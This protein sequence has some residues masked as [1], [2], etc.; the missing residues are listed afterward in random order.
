[1]TELGVVLGIALTGLGVA[2]YLLRWLLGRPLG[3]SEMNRVAGLVRDAAERFAR[4][5][6]STIGALAALVGLMLVS[7]LRQTPQ[8]FLRRLWV[9]DASDA[10]DAII[11]D[12]HHDHAAH[13]HGRWHTRH[14]HFSSRGPRTP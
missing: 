10:S 4:R 2:G 7:L 12:G 13:T 14:T 1:M 5:Q 11:S 3:D 6:S 8:Q 9:S